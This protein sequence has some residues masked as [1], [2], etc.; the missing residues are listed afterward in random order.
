M[1]AGRVPVVAMIVGPAYVELVHEIA[2]L[3]AGSRVGLVCA[4]GRGSDNI[5]ETLTLS[6]TSGVEIVTA[7]IDQPEDLER[8]DQTA[9]LILLSREAL[10]AGL[11]RHVLA[12]RSASGRGRTTSTRRASNCCDGRSST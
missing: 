7:L 4:S 11:D 6:G 3:P 2:G 10:A 8:V 12:D 5:R 9:D 1:S